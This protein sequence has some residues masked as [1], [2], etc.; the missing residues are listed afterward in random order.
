MVL[1]RVG[2]L[3]EEDIN[4]LNQAC[5]LLEIIKFYS[6]RGAAEVRLKWILEKFPDL[7]VLLLRGGR[8]QES[9][10]SLAF[11]TGHIGRR[12]KVII[13]STSKISVVL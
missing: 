2:Y 10:T 5:P 9:I 8:Y 4:S 13:F 3:S 12:L 1:N 6:I 7:K 11:I